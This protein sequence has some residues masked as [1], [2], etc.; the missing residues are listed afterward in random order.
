MNERYRLH[1]RG[2]HDPT[3]AAYSV[4]SSTALTAVASS[5]T[6]K[7]A[8]SSPRD[9]CRQLDYKGHDRYT[10]TASCCSFPIDDVLAAGEDETDALSLSQTIAPCKDIAGSIYISTTPLAEAVQ[11]HCTYLRAVMRVQMQSS[12]NESHVFSATNDIDELLRT[13][14]KDSLQ[15]RILP[16]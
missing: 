5:R 4:S 8:S 14:Q 1:R 16:A 10:T 9:V 3:L 7:R 11:Q 13:L 12:L 2:S 15:Q 6:R